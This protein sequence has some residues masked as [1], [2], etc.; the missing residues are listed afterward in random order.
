MLISEVLRILDSQDA[1][2]REAAAPAGESFSALM[3]AEGIAPGIPPAPATIQ[4]EGG[5]AAAKGNSG[6]PRGGSDLFP[7]ERR[8][9][10]S[11]LR[12]LEESKNP[13]SSH[14]LDLF[15]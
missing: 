6:S 8:S 13:P 10:D 14:A 9:Y 7:V 12:A 1:R 15:Q 4:G 5:D 2:P 3:A 11:F